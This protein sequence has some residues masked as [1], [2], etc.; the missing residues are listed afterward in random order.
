MP[1]TSVDSEKLGLGA[2]RQIQQAGGVGREERRDGERREGVGREEKEDEK[3]GEGE[4]EERREKK[5][6]EKKNMAW[7]CML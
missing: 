2:D 7:W 1:G 3:R 6:G 5:R 4:T